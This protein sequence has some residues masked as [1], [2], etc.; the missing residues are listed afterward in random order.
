MDYVCWLWKPSSKS[1]RYFWNNLLSVLAT[2]DDHVLSVLAIL[3]N[4]CAAAS[5]L[6][7]FQKCWLLLKIMD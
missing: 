4:L 3:Q 7:I 5:A 6:I 2:F 1:A